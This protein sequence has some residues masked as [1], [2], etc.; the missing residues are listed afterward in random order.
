MKNQCMNNP[1]CN[2]LDSQTRQLICEHAAITFQ[3]LK[4]MQAVNQ[5]SENFEIIIEGV[6]LTFTL[7]EDGT[8]ESIQLVKSGDILGTHLLFEKLQSPV[9]HTMSLTEVKRCN[10]P[11]RFIESLF[12]ENRQFAQALMK[13]LTLD[14]ASSLSNWVYLRS[15]NGPEKVAYIYKLLQKLNVDMNFITQEDLALIAGVSRITVARA[16]KDIYKK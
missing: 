2:S 3:K 15:K 10:L 11:V 16:M 7:L 13:N 12:H 9:T 5:G 6:L 4:Q 8:Q 14:H 1:F